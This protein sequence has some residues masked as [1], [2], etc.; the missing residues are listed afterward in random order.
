MLPAEYLL[1]SLANEREVLRGEIERLKV[2]L[3]QAQMERRRKIEY[4]QI[5]ERINTLPSR[6][7]LE[8][9][10]RDMPSILEYGTLI[11]L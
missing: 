10:V 4:D 6:A 7:E 11:F 9:Y 8:M 1:S 3:E 2:A 5:A